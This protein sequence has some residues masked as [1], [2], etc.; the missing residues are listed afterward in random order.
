MNLEK[1]WKKRLKDEFSKDY[2]LELIEFVKSEYKQKQIY[3]PGPH[4]FRAF[5]E[6][7]FDEV[8]VVIIGQDPYHTP[9]VANGLAFSVNPDKKVPP[10]LKNIYKELYADLGVEP[11]EDGDLSSWA[12]DGVLLLNSILTVEKGKPGSH[13]KKG[14]ETFT[15]KVIEVLNEEKSNLVFILWGNYAR[16]KGSS[17]D[18]EK[19]LVLESPHP[20]PFSAHQGFFGSKPFGKANEYL[21]SHEKEIIE[22]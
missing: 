17:I 5:E 20:S 21:F 13:Q 18:R 3:P 4:I 10:S 12:R 19:H 11:R 8:K 22:W 15:D 1:T 2:F 16:E 9:D 14:W 6:T 7:P